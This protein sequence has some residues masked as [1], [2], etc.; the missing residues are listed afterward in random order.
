MVSSYTVGNWI[1]TNSCTENIKRDEEYMP[2]ISEIHIN[3]KLG[4]TMR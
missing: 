3:P 4:V 2:E 1:N